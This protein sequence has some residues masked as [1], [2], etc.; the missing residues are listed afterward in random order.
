ME[1]DIDYFDVLKNFNKTEECF[2]E[3]IHSNEYCIHCKE[4]SVKVIK[5]EYICSKC[6]VSF[7]VVIDSTQEWRNFADDSRNSDPNRCGM[8]TNPLFKELSSGSFIAWKP[9]EPFFMKEIRRKNIWIS[10]NYREKSL[11]TVF[12]NMASRAKSYG[13]PNCIIERAKYKYKEISELKISRGENRTGI[14]AS[15]LFIACYENK[16]RRSEKEIANIF[17]IPSTSMTKGLKKY[18]EIMLNKKPDSIKANETNISD[19][20]DFIK[21]FC[22]NLE[23]NNQNTDIC[24]YVCQQIEEYHLV[25]ENTPCSR[26]AGCIYLV[27]YL[28]D[29]KESKKKIAEIC[30]TSEVTITKCFSKLI[31]FYIYLIPEEMLKFLALD[32]IHK[33]SSILEKYYDKKVYHHFLNK[34]LQLFKQNYNSKILNKSRDV[35]ILAGAVVYNLLKELKFTNLG[36]DDVCDNFYLKKYDILK[37]ND[38]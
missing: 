4:E 13:I 15:C 22:S 5:G 32:L 14:I 3:D 2:K 10:S 38:K 28:F 23:M 29:L 12:E 21:R 30:K 16:S 20:K 18:N 25:S 36:I 6:S 31:E 17:M 9:N 33:F 27:S 24:F 11:I 26:A 35:T 37:Y 8:P 1:N 19:S 34:S 7:G